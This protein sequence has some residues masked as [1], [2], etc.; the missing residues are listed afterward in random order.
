[1]QVMGFGQYITSGFDQYEGHSAIGILKEYRQGTGSSTGQ[2]I[3]SGIKI[4]I[5][6]IQSAGG[7]FGTGYSLDVAP[8]GTVSGLE[9]I[10]SMP[11]ISA[12]IVF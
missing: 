8:L 11:Y 5:G 2:L 1:M 7:I 6:V 12:S 4:I 9:P 3:F 10:S